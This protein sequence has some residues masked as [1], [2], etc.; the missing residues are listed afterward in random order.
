MFVSKNGG[1]QILDKHG[2]QVMCQKLPSAQED[3]VY[4][5]FIV[6]PP[7]FRKAPAAYEDGEN[8]WH[9]GKQLNLK[10]N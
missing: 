7:G 5:D 3:Y 6:T 1:I 2:T 9:W 10:T 4:G 8:T